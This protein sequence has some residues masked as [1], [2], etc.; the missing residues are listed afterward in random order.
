LPPSVACTSTQSQAMHKSAP[1][2]RAG[3][4]RRH[5]ASLHGANHRGRPAASNSRSKLALLPTSSLG[6]SATAWRP[7]DA[8]QSTTS[9]ATTNRTTGK[10]R[11]NCAGICATTSSTP[12]SCESWI[13]SATEPLDRPIRSRGS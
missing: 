12:S 3:S 9:R 2:S 10:H 7:S 13:G 6:G 4:E 11:T 1:A 5:P 8:L